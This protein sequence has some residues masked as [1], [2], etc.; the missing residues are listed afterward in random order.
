MSNLEKNV[1]EYAEMFA[2]ERA[3]SFY[4]N[5]YKENS[6]DSYIFK[7]Q[8]EQVFKF[9][10]TVIKPT[11]N[12]LHFDF[13]CGT[14]R[15]I[16]ALGIFYKNQFGYDIN[17]EMLKRVELRSVTPFLSTDLPLL[18]NKLEVKQNVVVTS[19]R[20]FLNTDLSGRD[21]LFNSC[22]RIASNRDKTLLI[23]D[24]HGT[25]PSIRNLWIKFSGKDANNFSRKEFKK[26]IN[27]NNCELIKTMHVQYL[28]G[29]LLKWKLFQFVNTL[30]VSFQFP[31]LSIWDTHFVRIK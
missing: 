12:D 21:S 4:D 25:S 11:E 31:F 16:S 3:A 18:E 30:L 14:G 17:E 7:L 8:R 27:A 19:F 22:K 24:I 2:S 20:F 13:A 1:S 15:W 23:L 9:L 29:S 10:T 6:T 28:P 5:L 26:Y